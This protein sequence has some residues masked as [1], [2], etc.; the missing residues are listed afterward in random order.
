MLT[1]EI[2][3]IS[4][5]ETVDISEIA[6]TFGVV[7]GRKY[8][9]VSIRKSTRVDKNRGTIATISKNGKFSHL[10]EEYRQQVIEPY[11]ERQRRRGV[12]VNSPESVGAGFDAVGAVQVDVDERQGEP[13][14]SVAAG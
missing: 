8:P 7:G 13:A 5:A 10:Y 12:G 4:D 1:E 11:L 9:A 2:E 6:P 14:Y 3:D